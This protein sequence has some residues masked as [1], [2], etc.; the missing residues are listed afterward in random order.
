VRVNTATLAGTLDV[1]DGS[2]H[3]LAAV[4]DG[5]SLALYVD[6][7]L[8]VSQPFAATTIDVN[9][10]LLFGRHFQGNSQSSSQWESAGAIDEVRIYDR[11]LSPQEIA[12]LTQ[13]TPDDQTPPLR[14]NAKP[15]GV[16]PPGTEAWVMVVDT[17]EA[18]HCRWSEVPGTPFGAMPHDFVTTGALNHA[19]DVVGLVDGGA[20]TYAVRCIDAAGNANP[21]DL[22]VSFSVDTAG[23]SGSDLLAHWSFEENGGHLAFDVS[24]N[25]HDAALIGGPQWVVGPDGLALDLSG[26]SDGGE[27]AAGVLPGP[28][29][30]LSV[31][32]WIRHGST[33]SFSSIVDQRDGVEDGYDL[34]LSDTGMAFA[35]VN[36]ATLVGTTPI[37]DGTWHHLVATWNGAELRL[38][39]DGQLDTLTATASAPI[40]VVSPLRLGRHFQLNSTFESAGT[41]DEVRLYNRALSTPEVAA[42]AGSAGPRINLAPNFV[43]KH[44]VQRVGTTA[45][46]PLGGS[47]IGSPTAIEARLIYADSG[48]P[49]SGFDWTVVDA[50]PT[51]G[52]WGGVLPGAPQGG[53]YRLELR[54]AN[55]PAVSLEPTSRLGVGMVI[56]MLGQS[57]MAKLFTEITFDGDGDLG[58]ASQDTPAALTQ[59]YGYGGPRV[60]ANNVGGYLR[61]PANPGTLHYG[62]VTGAAGIRFANQLALLLNLPVLLLDFAIDGTSIL[63][64][65][66]PQWSGRQTFDSGLA[67]LGGDFE[68]MVWFQGGADIASELPASVYLDRLNT[69]YD[70]IQAQLPAGRT[71]A[72]LEAI[73][74]RGD[75]PQA[76]DAAYDAI[77][78][79]QLEWPQQHP[80]VYPAGTAIDLHLAADSFHRGHG[81]FTAS[82]YQIMAD[83]Y[84]AAILDFLST[85]GYEGGVAGPHVADAVRVGNQITVSF[86]HDQGTAL[87]L[88]DPAADIEG[89][90]IS[91]DGFATALR[92]GDGIVSARLSADS[93]SVVLHLATLPTGP[94]ELRYLHGMNPFGHKA[95]QAQRRANG[96]TV[97]D[98]FQYHP[99]RS[100]LPVHP[101]TGN[102]IVSDGS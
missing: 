41:I 42:L 49:I 26:Q 74:G 29:S 34:F 63:E 81:H 55:D 83:R 16:L 62:D 82:Q 80:N 78:K 8:D 94:I 65:T 13:I 35:R 44:V 37:T 3:H 43:D 64:W 75:Y 2:W 12:A 27:V 33:S 5:F 70:Q 69:L 11:P 54:F 99:E 98:D 25:G 21:D 93:Q 58:V 24:G 50:A 18:A 23:T 10:P 72:W 7:V 84:T 22:L 9:A 88:P 52:N 45:D 90:E 66:D 71:L 39:V 87:T 46:L 38:Y 56:A 102:L 73:Q 59:R 92:L 30:A 20:Y 19:T 61:S 67:T 31:A 76:N 101:T 17:G 36:N 53:W 77:R 40:D 1:T 85:P 86:S 97:Y 91:G 15:S 68:L 28:H 60:S 79:V 6:G 96:N 100:G 14:S 57:S 95:S 47:Y 89:F 4:W 48:A 51:G 32:A